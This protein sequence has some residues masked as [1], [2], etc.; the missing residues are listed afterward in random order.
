MIEVTQAIKNATTSAAEF[1]S[2]THFSQL[3]VEEVE[4]NTPD[5]Q[6]LITLGFNILEQ[7]TYKN[8]GRILQND[9]DQQYDR[10]YKIFKV[11][12]Q[13]GEVLSMKIREI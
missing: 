12:D 8:I 3:Q 13:T 1:L 4:H 7:K 6:W 2:S 9:H 11:N 10:K 5:K